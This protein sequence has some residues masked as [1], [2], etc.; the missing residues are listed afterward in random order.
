MCPRCGRAWP[1]DAQLCTCGH[2]FRTQFTQPNPPLNVTQAIPIAPTRGGYVQAWWRYLAPRLALC[3]VLVALGWGG[4]SLLKR[5]VLNTPAGNWQ[6]V[7][8]STVGDSIIVLNR[9]GS[10]WGYQ[11]LALY[12]N[13][14]GHDYDLKW[15]SQDSNMYFRVDDEATETQLSYAMSSDGNHLSIRSADGKIMEYLRMEGEPPPRPK[16]NRDGGE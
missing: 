5:T 6:S 11:R 15:R 12:G 3:A 1:L 4:W 10:G 9:D 7:I 13:G 2:Q 14:E 8:G 16:Q